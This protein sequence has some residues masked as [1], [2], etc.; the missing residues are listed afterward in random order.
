MIYK[1]ILNIYM[2]TVSD[3]TAKSF[4]LLYNSSENRIIHKTR[5]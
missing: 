2:F 5:T 4:G 1:T 3:G